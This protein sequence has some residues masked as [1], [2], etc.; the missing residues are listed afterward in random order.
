MNEMGTSR[1]KEGARPMPDYSNLR[2][3]PL[4]PVHGNPNV[5]RDAVLFLGARL[6]FLSRMRLAKLLFIAE[7][8]SI[9]RFGRPLTAARFESHQFGPYT[10]DLEAVLDQMEKDGLAEIKQVKTKR[11]HEM[12]QVTVDKSAPIRSL[13]SKGVALL[14]FV[15]REYGFMKNDDL[16]RAS[17]KHRAFRETLRGEPIDLAGYLFEKQHPEADEPLKEQVRQALRETKAGK[18]KSFATKEELLVHLRAL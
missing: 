2:S 16:V 14:E 3:D 11:D 8:E 4:F 12:G 5:I 9:D 17:K 7:L 6:K 13:D 15:I 1:D 18:G 10:N